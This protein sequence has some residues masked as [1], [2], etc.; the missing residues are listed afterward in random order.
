MLSSKK[1][2]NNWVASRNSL[3]C[4]VTKK[5]R[6]YVYIIVAVTIFSV[7]ANYINYKLLEDYTY[8]FEVGKK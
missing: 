2:S 4:Y 1:L 3:E 6:I 7:L 5:K 8:P